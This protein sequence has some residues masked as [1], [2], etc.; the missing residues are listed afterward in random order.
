MDTRT[1][2]YYKILGVGRTASEKDIKS[3]YRK[4]A[5]KYHPDVN[6]GD[7]SAEDKFKEIGE[8]YEVLSDPEKRRR[9]DQ[10]GTGWARG[11]QGVPPGWEVFRPAGAAPRRRAPAGRRPARPARP[12]RRPS[13]SRRPPGD[14]GEFFD[15]LLGRGASGATRTATRPR[16]G[17]DL[18]QEVSVTL[19]E[20]YNGGLR[21][22]VID[23][24]D[25]PGAP[26][27][28]GSRSRSRPGC[29]TGR[30]CASP[31]KGHPG[32]NNAGPRG[33]LYLRIRLAPHERLERRGDD[34]YADVPVPLLDAVLGGEVEVQTL[35]GRGHVPHPA[36]DAEREDLPP[37]RA[38]H[39]QDGR[40][41]ARGDFYARV[42]VVLPER[43]DGRERELFEELR[44][45]R[46]R[47]GVRSG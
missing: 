46:P 47:R 38:G 3:A 34:L 30:A 18:E 40:R 39:A 10:F 14:L 9:Y 28:S 36:G 13:T 8:A 42:K 2:D 23:V 6:P 35:S 19:E 31:G 41:R 26:P 21:E 22:F 4:L 17:E 45:L 27:G 24:P 11:P 5:R 1:K 33:D 7:K 20:A 25:A 44:K 37:R 43:A 12:G 16:A 15:S 32:F 29:G